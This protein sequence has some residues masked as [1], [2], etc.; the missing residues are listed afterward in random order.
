MI[1]NG[2]T[3]EPFFGSIE[4]WLD[5]HKSRPGNKL[6]QTVFYSISINGYLQ[7][8]AKAMIST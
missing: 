1:K 3:I 8:S 2:S 4:L 7:A 6:P 5:C